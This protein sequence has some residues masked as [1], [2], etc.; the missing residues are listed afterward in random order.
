MFEG[1]ALFPASGEP[2]DGQATFDLFS[3]RLREEGIGSA[4]E[5]L[6]ALIERGVSPEDPLAA[7]VL[8]EVIAALVRAFDAVPLSPAAYDML[9]KTPAAFASVMFDLV[10][11]AVFGDQPRDLS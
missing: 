10:L 3:A 6:A 5:I 8:N 2:A 1:V 4:P 9:A 11:N 7:E